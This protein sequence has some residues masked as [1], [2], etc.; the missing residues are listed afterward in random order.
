MLHYLSNADLNKR[1]A[2]VI[3]QM[4][5]CKAFSEYTQ[6]ALIH[7]SYGEAPDIDALTD[8]FGFQH[9]FDIRPVPSLPDPQLPIYDLL[10]GISKVSF[11]NLYLLAQIVATDISPTDTVYMRSLYPGAAFTLWCSRLPK[12]KR[13]KL[14]YEY[15]RPV[16]RQI[17]E[18]IARNVDG[19]VCITRMLKERA[20]KWYTIAD[21]RCH[22]APDGVNPEKYDHISK[23]QARTDLGLPTDTDIVMYTGHLYPRKGV[24]YL[25]QAADNI[26]AEVYI[27][28]GMPDDIIRMVEKYGYIPNLHFT[29]FVSPQK[30]HKYQLSADVLVAPYTKDAWM[31]SPLKLFEYMATGNP[32]IVS[33]IESIR[34]V[35]SHQENGYLVPPNSTQGLCSAVNKILSNYT[36]A[37]KMGEKAKLDSLNYSWKNRANEILSF[38]QGVDKRHG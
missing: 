29:G 9:E 35:I 28:G 1:K 14:I 17:E 5:M 31:P 21:N 13:P 33:N 2:H 32:I 16:N 30:I 25:A 10:E 8:Q 26:D 23:D 27:V 11:V 36:E 12:T 34:E 38:I 22:I 6:T 7:P 3:Q 19:L 18:K 15:H 4:E 37:Q 24:Q 20:K